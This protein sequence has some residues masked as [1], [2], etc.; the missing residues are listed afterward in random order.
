[1]TIEKNCERQAELSVIQPFTFADFVSGA[2]TPAVQVPGGAIVTGGD[3]I[4][5]TAFDSTVSD[6]FTIGDATVGNR[7]G[8]A[9]D[10]QAAART[11]LVPTGFKYPTQ[12][13]VTL[14]WTG[15]GAA[16]TAGAGRLI[17]RYV[18]AGRA[19]TTQG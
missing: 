18:V 2:D 4:I 15:A 14:N 5:D 16:P 6:T 1:M 17:M 7:Y 10:G 8:A 12:D 9:I 13:N 3:F 19:Q 11:A